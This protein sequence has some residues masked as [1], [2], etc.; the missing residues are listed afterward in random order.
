M[1]TPLF[2]KLVV[3]LLLH[4][5]LVDAWHALTSILLTRC[6]RGGEITHQAHSD[7]H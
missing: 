6:Y 3:T 7:S 1:P 4:C 5:R 2:V